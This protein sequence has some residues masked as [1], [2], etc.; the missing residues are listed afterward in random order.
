M[1]LLF[2]RDYLPLLAVRYWKL[3]DREES[4][5]RQ[6]SLPLLSAR[7]EFGKA[8]GAFQIQ[9]GRMYSAFFLRIQPFGLD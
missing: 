7:E 4:T 6:K 3:E 9:W 8:F 2:F 5:N 1:H